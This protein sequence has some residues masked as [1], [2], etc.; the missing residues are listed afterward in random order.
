VVVDMP[1]VLSAYGIGLHQLLDS[2]A[3]QCFMLVFMMGLL[4]YCYK[5]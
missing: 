2:A 4:G 3:W 5:T 1:A